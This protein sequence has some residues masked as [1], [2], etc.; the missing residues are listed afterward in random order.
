MG[1]RRGWGPDLNRSFRAG[2]KLADDIT[3]GLLLGG[4]ATAA[5]AYR[6]SRQPKTNYSPLTMRE[7]QELEELEMQLAVPFRFTKAIIWHSIASL[8]ALAFPILGAYLY[9]YEDWWMFFSV[10]ICGMLEL[11]LL[12]P[13]S[14][15]L[16]DK[17]ESEWIFSATNKEKQIKQVKILLWLSIITNVVLIV[18]N[19]YPFIVYYEGGILV[20]IMTLCLYVAN[21][22]C[23]YMNAK[24]LKNI[25]VRFEQNINKF[26][27]LQGVKDV[28]KSKEL[29]QQ[30]I[31][32]S[33]IIFSDP[34]HIQAYIDKCNS[35]Q[36]SM[37]VIKANIR[38]LNAMTDSYKKGYAE[39]SYKI[40]EQQLEEKISLA[41]RDFVKRECRLAFDI[42]N[43]L[44]TRSIED[45]ITAL[46]QKYPYSV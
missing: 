39:L 2:S 6:K 14:M 29:Q 1:Y 34:K 21:G 5:Y 44:K 4:L 19:S 18:L 17:I 22:G 3:K 7:Q 35:D 37:E 13:V 16:E 9:C 8:L 20:T 40:I 46:K 26:G 12:V 36:I 33:E 45:V 11:C 15:L 10:L 25:N 31:D 42:L 43:M 30:P 23:I 32:N 41:K 28:R 38:I 27:R 24:E